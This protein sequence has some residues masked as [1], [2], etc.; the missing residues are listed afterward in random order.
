MGCQSPSRPSRPGTR[1]ELVQRSQPLLGTFVVLS[2]YATNRLQAHDAISA[3][4]AEIQRIDSLMS[5]H[6]PDSELVRVNE[7]AAAGPVRVSPDLFRVLA[8]A[9][10]IAAESEGGFDVTIRPLAQ[11]WGFIWKEYRL[12]TAS[13]LERTLPFVSHR[14]LVL[15]SATQTVRFQIPGMSLDLGG[16]AKGYAVDCAIEK[17]RALGVRDA[18]VR[19][20]GDLRVIGAPPGVLHWEVQLEDP[21]KTGHRTVI[22]LR[23]AAVSTSGNYENFFIVDGKRY[24]HIM[25]PRT[26]LP[27]ENIAACSVIAPTCMES[28]A[29][30]TALVV[31]GAERSIQKFGHRFGMQF[32]LAPPDGTR[33]EL[34]SS[35]FPRAR[36]Q[37]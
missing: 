33:S 7:R 31:Y 27:V 4:F 3:A 13:E 16:I 23:E 18:L 12:P 17:L 30:A 26:G 19:A 8:K 11:L 21:Q 15:D 25:D 5:L 34:R 37:R 9:Q 36:N 20:G 32:T 2:V 6:R 29:W 14:R 10:E 35:S 1:A 28:D 22:P 24:S